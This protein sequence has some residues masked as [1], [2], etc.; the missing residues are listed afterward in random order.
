MH[1]LQKSEK[2]DVQQIHSSGN[3][4]GLFTKSLPTST[5]KKLTHNIIMLQLKDIDARE[6]YVYDMMLVYCTIFL[7]IQVLLH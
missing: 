3:F 4:T 6:R 1:E 5:F 7:F 2:I